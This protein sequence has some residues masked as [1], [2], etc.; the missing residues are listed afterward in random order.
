MI[1][2]FFDKVRYKRRQFKKDAIKETARK[3]LDKEN[4]F[5]LFKEVDSVSQSTGVSLTDYAAIFAYVKKYKPHTI[6]ECGTGKTTWVISLA[7]QELS[8]ADPHYR[9]KLVSMEHNEQW[10]AEAVKN[11]PA[12]RFPFVEIKYSPKGVFGYGLVRGTVYQT[13]P[14]Y[15]YDFVLV[16]GPGQGIDGV[17]AGNMD[18]IRVVLNSK[19][20][21]RALIDN[22]KA[23]IW[24]YA[25]IFGPNK[26][27]F[28][29]LF[30]LGIVDPV[31][32]DDVLIG[33]L[34][35]MK[36]EFSNYVTCDESNLFKELLDS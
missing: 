33:D 27:R 13:V 26:V 31:S 9:P 20:P 24:A 19:N 30:S 36:R 14:D 1:N 15:D 17:L 23:T 29:E 4:L 28:N 25:V 6:L 21:V 10:H 5:H 35:R 12:E 11:F 3:Y 22:R 16:D 18:F 7:M 2:E 32:K 8:L 34:D